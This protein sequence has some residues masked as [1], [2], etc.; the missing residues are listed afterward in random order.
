[1]IVA[2][3]M[4]AIKEYITHPLHFIRALEDGLAVSSQLIVPTT[5]ANNNIT[6]ICIVLDLSFN[7][8]S[9]DPVKLFLK[10]TVL[11]RVLPPPND[12]KM[13][14]SNNSLS[15]SWVAPDSL[16]VSTP[17]TISHYVLKYGT[18]HLGQY[19]S[20]NISVASHSNQTVPAAGNTS[21]TPASNNTTSAV[22]IYGTA[23]V[24][25]VLVTV[26]VVVL[27]IAVVRC[28]K[29][30]QSTWTPNDFGN[31]RA[32]NTSDGLSNDCPSRAIGGNTS[33]TPEQSTGL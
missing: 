6:V 11:I 30:K 23:P 10:G 26:I 21:S 29:K 33:C 32:V 8:Q 27:V 19:F 2:H 25:A 28:F 12:L 22:H 18:E 3:L 5:K 9:S 15:L 7:P 17:P 4:L 24:C 14:V 13:N 31:E 16:Q 1:M 20:N